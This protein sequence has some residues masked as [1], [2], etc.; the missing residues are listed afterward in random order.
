MS[1]DMSAEELDCLSQQF[2]SALTKNGKG[3]ISLRNLKVLLDI[4]PSRP[5]AALEAARHFVFSEEEMPCN[6]AV[7]SPMSLY[8]FLKR[9]G[10]ADK[11]HHFY[12]KI[13]TI[14]DL[15]DIDD[16]RKTLCSELKPFKVSAAEA[17]CIDE[18]IKQKH[19]ETGN[20]INFSYHGRGRIMS[21]FMSFYTNPL[22]DPMF[23]DK[24]MRFQP[25]H[26]W[27][28]TLVHWR[29]AR[30]STPSVPRHLE[31]ALLLVC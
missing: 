6:G 15:K 1:T 18:I 5:R 23:E 14:Q 13:K 22:D 10:I 7:I 11:Y 12:P 24:K 29:S 4:H 31:V 8:E 21:V 16:L 28:L 17:V 2:C 9:V 20:L 26:L 27:S 3:A 30:T 25:L 19:S